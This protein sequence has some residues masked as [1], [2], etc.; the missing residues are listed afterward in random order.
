I[1][2][3][4]PCVFPVLSIKVLAL[5]E[6]AGGS[7]AGGR[8]HG[9]AYTAGVLAAFT[10]LGVLLLGVRAAGAE[11]GWGFQLQ[12]PVAVALLAYLLAATGLRLSG[13]VHLGFALPG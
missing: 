13:V 6:Q 2:N 10:A 12:S 8:P 3:L 5:T 1:L 4:M 11:V 9:I 7:G